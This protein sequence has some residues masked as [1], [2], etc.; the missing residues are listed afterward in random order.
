M[1][2]FYFHD[3]ET[4]G[5]DP[6]RDWP[7]QFAG[8]RTDANFEEVGQPLNIYCR[9]PADQIPHPEACLVT[10]LTPDIVNREGVCEAEFIAR[11]HQEFITS[12]TCA[13]GYNSLRFDDEVTRHSL[14]RN[15]YS[16]Y[17]REWKNGCS[18]WDLIDV[19]RLCAAL[20][21]E[22]IVWPR[23]DDGTHSFRLEELTAANGITHAA[24]HDALSDVRATIAMARLLREKQ[25]RL[26][27]HALKHRTKHKV[28]G[29][30]D[31]V[32]MQPDAVAHVSGM[33]P[34]NR[35]CLAV[36]V[37][38]AVHPTNKNEI[39]VYDLSI[40]P[41]PLLSLDVESVRYRLFTSNEDLQREGVER[42]PIKTIHINRCPVIVLLKV[43]TAADRE[44]LGIHFS[45][46]KKNYRKLFGG[47]KQVQEMRQ[48]LS[49]VYGQRDYEPVSDPDH[50]LY[51]GGFF[52]N[53]DQARIAQIRTTSPEELGNV[54][55]PFRD[56]RLE[57][58]LFRYRARNWPELLT[59]EE[60]DRW[61]SFRRQ[62]LEHGCGGQSHSVASCLQSIQELLAKQDSEK[63]REVLRQLQ[64][65]V[66]GLL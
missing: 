6:A 51:S 10:G 8:I 62:R 11:I 28:A 34:A 17:D 42:I 21:P 13:L 43:V 40:D 37:P 16:P 32:S 5:T 58:M 31:V 3:Y 66:T 63:K 52:S 22:G 36:V 45:T 53:D 50:M 19:V 65:Y 26:F 1:Q 27:D 14:Y 7:A 33:Y 55:L 15:F 56:S 2:T 57:E 23:R 25:P 39:I 38:L 18:R 64:C 60:V 20:R 29:M 59:D 30:L 48:K 41:E 49:L 24:A 35:H 12:N 61:N 4:F 44:R 54:S 46:C 9:L 47:Y